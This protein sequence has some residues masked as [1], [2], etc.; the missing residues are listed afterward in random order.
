MDDQERRDEI[1]REMRAAN[2]PIVDGVLERW[3]TIRKAEHWL[4]LP[5]ELSH[6]HLPDLVAAVIEAAVCTE[7]AEAPLRAVVMAAAE[8]G[9][10]RRAAGFA[11]GLIF[12][13]YYLLRS[14]LWTV[15]EARWGAEP[16]VFDVLARVDS[17][18]T[19]ATGG[20]LRGFHREELEARGEWP[21]SL[22]AVVR[23]WRQRIERAR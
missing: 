20:S 5:D 17:S 12:R 16:G 8:H 15:L 19:A 21:E 13:E 11:E 23:E 7:F 9:D 2:G 22:D 6:D 4:E 1:C 10:Q 18:I 14:A 3:D